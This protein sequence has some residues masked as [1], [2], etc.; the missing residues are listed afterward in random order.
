MWERKTKAGSMKLPF[1]KGA[2]FGVA[3]LAVVLAMTAY[4][5]RWGPPAC[6]A[7]ATGLPLKPK[8]IF[9]L[10]IGFGPWAKAAFPVGSCEADLIAWMDRVGFGEIEKSYWGAME[11]NSNDS[12]AVENR[13]EMRRI[14][15]IPIKRRILTKWVFVGNSYFV[16]AWDA[17]SSGRITEIYADAKLFQ[18][19][20]FNLP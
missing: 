18:I 20:I 14:A 2:K 5:T 10:S 3:V 12:E 16:V 1:G 7:T 11:F 9:G 13:S 4:D 17:D 6:D 15:N 19:F 8:M